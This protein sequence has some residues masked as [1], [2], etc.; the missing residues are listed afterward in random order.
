M[1]AGYR[2]LSLVLG[3]HFGIVHSWAL[4]TF[5][6]LIPHQLWSVGFLFWVPVGSPVVA[7]WE[8]LPALGLVR[9]DLAFVCA[10]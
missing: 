7:N 8:P 1:A 5:Q 3:V 4:G 2:S 9:L 6:P 10:V